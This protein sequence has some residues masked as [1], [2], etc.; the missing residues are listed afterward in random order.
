MK[1]PEIFA[2]TKYHRKKNTEFAMN[3]FNSEGIS[4]QKSMFYFKYLQEFIHFIKKHNKF[5]QIMIGMKNKQLSVSV[6]EVK[7]FSL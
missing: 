5:V 1:F 3:I 4:R 6:E 2:H 7:L